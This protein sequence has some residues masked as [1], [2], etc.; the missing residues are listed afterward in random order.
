MATSP[1]A[2]GEA[3]DLVV[4]GGGLQGLSTALEAAR[5]GLG[6]R[7]IEAGELGGGASGLNGG[8]VIPGLKQNPE[9]LL[10]HFGDGLGGRL[11]GF[12]ETTA[13][14]VF[15]LI[16]REKLAAD[17]VRA[18]WV[19]ACHTHAAVHGTAERHRQWKARGADVAL[20]NGA[21]TALLTG[22]N[23]Y[24]GGWLD[25]RAGTV[26][27]LALTLELARIATEAGVRISSG[28]AVASLDRDGTDWRVTTK[29]GRSV[30][31]PKVLVATNAYSD[32]LVPGLA[33]SLV[34]L[35]SFQIATAALTP[36][37]HEQ[38]L[39]HG[40][41]VSDSRR[42][43]TYYRKSPDGRFVIGGRGR[44]GLPRAASDWGH[45]EHAML[46]MFPFLAGIP[47]ERRWFGR[48]AM[49]ADHLP[50]LHEPEK[51]LLMLAGCQ[52]RG[53]A[54]MTAAGVPLA[55]YVVG[56]DPEVLPFPVSPIRTIPFHAFRQVGVAA[57]IAWYR[58][59]D[60]MER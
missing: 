56:G 26:N 35:H 43:V 3:V 23:G 14:H 60:R 39:P 21:E 12:S 25:R 10:E 34:P 46:R 5:R 57:L 48:V 24:F 4:V 38:I 52:G 19:M 44:M 32:R 49:T 50:H 54:L 20:L 22:V 45:L 47:I 1:V 2:D 15:G 8:Q 42:I 9:W 30:R 58:M 6:V 37:Q 33:Q 11:V 59:L 41:A 40:Q 53:V 36:A 18:G 17:P 7:V 51:G 31:A 13:D 27:P 28:D 55:D 29:G 16:E